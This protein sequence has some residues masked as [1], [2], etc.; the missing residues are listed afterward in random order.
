MQKYSFFIFCLHIVVNSYIQAREIEVYPTLTRVLLPSTSLVSLAPSSS[1]TSLDVNTSFD[2][3]GENDI[4]LKV[5]KLPTIE[6]D[7]ADQ[8]DNNPSPRTDFSK[9]VDSP[10]LQEAMNLVTAKVIPKRTDRVI[11]RS[12]LARYFAYGYL[13]LEVFGGPLEKKFRKFV[14][15]AC[16]KNYMIAEWYK[17]FFGILPK[18][19][20]G[21]IFFDKPDFEKRFE[22]LKSIHAG[23]PYEAFWVDLFYP[24][25]YGFQKSGANYI[26]YEQMLNRIN[27]VSEAKSTYL[28]Y[29]MMPFM[30]T[31]RIVVENLLSK[32][33]DNGF[34]LAQFEYAEVL[35]QKFLNRPSDDLFVMIVNYLKRAEK[36]GVTEA[37]QVYQDFIDESYSKEI[38]K[39]KIIRLAFPEVSRLPNTPLFDPKCYQSDIK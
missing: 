29:K 35:Y 12:A 31:D 20:E 37:K 32:S 15:Y 34:P 33:A 14:E 7:V 19:T 22:K 11:L 36:G 27:T 6:E 16:E 30:P 28:H 17:L 23:K 18:N 38:K 25:Q 2:K 4:N 10:V 13:P 21:G 8:E 1:N 9:D 39:Y 26:E 24:V 3:E 5:D